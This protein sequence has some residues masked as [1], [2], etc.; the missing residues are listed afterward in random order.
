VGLVEA[1][2]AQVKYARLWFVALV[3][4]CCF[5]LEPTDIEDILDPVIVSEPDVEVCEP[6]SMFIPM[7]EPRGWFSFLDQ[8]TGAWRQDPD[9][10]AR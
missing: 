10:I 9:I 4:V 5:R 6:P 8:E 2:E 1:A 7:P 3:A